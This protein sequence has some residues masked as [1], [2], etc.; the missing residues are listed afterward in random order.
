[1]HRLAGRDLVVGDEAGEFVAEG[2]HG[3]PRLP[4]VGIGSAS[5]K[6]GNHV[7]DRVGR[8]R[9]GHRLSIDGSVD[10]RHRRSR[11]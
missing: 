8:P 4:I 3:L 5:A 2:T 9:A 11:T 1:M 10:R 6:T 7:G